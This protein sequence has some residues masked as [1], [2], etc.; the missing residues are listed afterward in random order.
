M[1]NEEVG[2]YHHA[3]HGKRPTDSGWTISRL[4]LKCFG[5]TDVEML[6]KSWGDDC[7]ADKIADLAAERN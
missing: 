7:V 1:I 2:R 3:D 5:A 6:G 4:G